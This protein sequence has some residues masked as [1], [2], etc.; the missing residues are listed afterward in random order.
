MGKKWSLTPEHLATVKRLAELGVTEA[1]IA[2]AINLHPSTFVEKKRMHPELDE[3]IKLCQA[4]GEAYAASIIRQIMDDVHNKNR[5]A[6][7]VF[8]LKT[9]HKW[10]EQTMAEPVPDANSSEGFTFT[11]VQVPK[12][13]V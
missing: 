10:R 7:T 5:F 4:S 11:L 3:V 13:E 2:R 12:D 6:A 1:N 8:Y 9:R